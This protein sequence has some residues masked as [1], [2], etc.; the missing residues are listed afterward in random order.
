MARKSGEGVPAL[1]IDDVTG[2]TE[3]QEE[4]VI[5]EGGRAPRKRV[6]EDFLEEEQD[7]QTVAFPFHALAIR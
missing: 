4:E 6:T 3:E 2:M 1:Q 7:A 5:G